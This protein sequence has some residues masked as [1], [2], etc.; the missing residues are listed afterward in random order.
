MLSGPCGT[1]RW[2]AKGKLAYRIAS[3]IVKNLDQKECLEFYYTHD[4]RRAVLDAA[5]QTAADRIIEKLEQGLDVA[6]LTLGDPTST[7]L[8]FTFTASGKSPRI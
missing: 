1:G 6:C 4:K 3:G 7:A 2:Q 5:Y 8:I